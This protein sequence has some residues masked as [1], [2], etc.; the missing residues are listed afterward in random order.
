MYPNALFNKYTKHFIQLLGKKA[1]DNFKLD[2]F[3]KKLFGKNYLGTFAQDQL[4][5]RS[6]YLIINIDTS[7]RGH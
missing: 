6:G 2:E 5:T 3:G 7:K 4:P 1:L